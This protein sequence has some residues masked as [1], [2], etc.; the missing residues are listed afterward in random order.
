M[1]PNDREF[2]LLLNRAIESFWNVL[3]LG[4]QP[5]RV[6]WKNLVECF[7]C[8]SIYSLF[9]V[10]FSLPRGDSEN[11]QLSEPDRLGWGI[12]GGF[13]LEVLGGL[14]GLLLGW[15]ILAGAIIIL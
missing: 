5:F 1:P 14:E 2:S 4:I 15:C 12:G 11:E 3:W 13:G 9:N 10:Q 6:L 8:L 7:L